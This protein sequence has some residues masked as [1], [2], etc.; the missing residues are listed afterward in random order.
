MSRLVHQ[1]KDCLKE[2]INLNIRELYKQ[3]RHKNYDMR[4]ETSFYRPRTHYIDSNKLREERSIKKNKYQRENTK[5]QVIKK[6]YTDKGSFHSLIIK[7]AG[8]VPGPWQYESKRSQFD[9]FS[10]ADDRVGSVSKMMKELL[11]QWKGIGKGKTLESTTVR[12]F[13]S[14]KGQSKNV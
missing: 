6:P 9:K 12:F 1:G 3:N 14:D 10:T 2:G 8:M 5:G 7:K 11:K 4:W 13:K